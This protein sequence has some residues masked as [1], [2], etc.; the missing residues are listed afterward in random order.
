MATE[1]PTKTA[2]KNYVDTRDNAILASANNYT[3]SR[4]QSPVKKY[5][6][7][8]SISHSDL[9]G[10][11]IT[12]NMNVGWGFAI[13]A[14]QSGFDYKDYVHKVWAPYTITNVPYLGIRYNNNNQVTI[15]ADNSGDGSSIKKIHYLLIG[16][17]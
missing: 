2:V 6:G 8:L 9:R 17:Q 7:L 15:F 12:H 11:T 10:Y 16:F 13:F 1:V 14:R 3:N 4:T 5:T